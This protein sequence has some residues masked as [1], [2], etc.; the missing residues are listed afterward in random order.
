MGGFGNIA[1]TLGGVGNDVSNAQQANTALSQQAAADKLKQIMAGLQIQE[2]RNRLSEFGQAKPAGIEKTP[3]GG[4]AGFTFD[5]NSGTY[6]AQPLLPGAAPGV[7]KE[8]F[9]TSLLEYANRPDATALEKRVMSGL[10]GSLDAGMAP[11]KVMEDYNRFLSSRSETGTP[12]K[13]ELKTE[14]FGGYRWQYDPAKKL[15]GTRDAT[16]QYVRLGLAKEPGTGEGGTKTPFEL[17][18]KTHPGGSYDDW[19]ADSAKTK[20]IPPDVLNLLKVPVPENPTPADSQ[21][22]AQAAD[23]VFGGTAHRQDL[24]TRGRKPGFPIVGRAHYES[25]AYSKAEYQD[26]LDS[27]KD[28]VGDVGGATIQPPPGPPPGRTGKITTQ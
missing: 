1:R 12:P 2:I 20:P 15:S 18:L 25:A 10:I 4:I 22:L 28:S 9:R 6:K 5:P 16:G 27:I 24:I 21:R 13:D 14:I 7:D 11:E 19:I 23:K 8:K 17:W 3:E 26:I